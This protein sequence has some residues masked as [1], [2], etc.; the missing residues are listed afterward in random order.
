MEMTTID[1]KLLLTSDLVLSPTKHLPPNKLRPK[2]EVC[3]TSKTASSTGRRLAD[4]GSPSTF[5]R[6]RVEFGAM[7]TCEDNRAHHQQS[8]LS[9]TH[10]LGPRTLEE[11]DRDARNI[12]CA[13]AWPLQ[14][15]KVELTTRDT[16]KIQV[17]EVYREDGLHSLETWKL[18]S[19]FRK[20]RPPFQSRP[21][22]SNFLAEHSPPSLQPAVYGAFS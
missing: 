13:P 21:V 20:H 2:A 5:K 15:A 10:L 7:G 12:M 8:R 3:S 22:Q 14:P 19:I 11:K 16:A 17:E 9:S 6:G 1:T 4:D 18:C